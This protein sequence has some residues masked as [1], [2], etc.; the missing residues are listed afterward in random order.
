M[1]VQGMKTPDLL[2]EDF[3]PC[4]AVTL[5]DGK[6]KEWWATKTD[7]DFGYFRSFD[8]AERW[9]LCS[10]ESGFL[11]VIRVGLGDQ[12]YSA[13]EEQRLLAGGLKRGFPRFYEVDTP[14]VR[15]PVR[16][17]T[18]IAGDY[19]VFKLGDDQICIMDPEKKRIAL[20]ARG[21]GPVVAKPPLEEIPK[22]SPEET[23]EQ[24]ANE[25]P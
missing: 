5:G 4:S 20:I 3:S 24:T 17:G 2:L 8:N 7:R 1:D 14:F 11:L 23:N 22:K 21:F 25:V 12:P 9:D 19:G 15:W 13:A 10:E 16:N 6:Y 18:R